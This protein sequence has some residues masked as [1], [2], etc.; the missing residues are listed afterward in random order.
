MDTLQ[1]RM[2]YL[3]DKL[4]YKKGEFARDIG[5]SPT[6]ITKI[7]K[8]HQI[9][10][11]RRFFDAVKREFDINPISLETGQGEMFCDSGNGLSEKQHL[12]FKQ[13]FSLSKKR[14][15]IIDQTIMGF[16][17]ADKYED[18]SDSE[19]ISFEEE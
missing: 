8:G 19:T 15:D 7:L 4:G 9:T 13:Y 3:L 16:M 17:L 10:P 2:K 6:Y 1:D 18:Q 11:S 12:F 14:R 5:F